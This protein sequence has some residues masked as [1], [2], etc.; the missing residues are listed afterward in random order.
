MS[1]ATRAAV[2]LDISRVF[3]KVWHASLFHKLKFCGISGQMFYLS[4]SFLGN[5]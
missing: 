4:L 3:D 2:A 5:R 1:G